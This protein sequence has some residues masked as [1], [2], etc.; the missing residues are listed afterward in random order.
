VT[1]IS[2]SY[3]ARSSLFFIKLL[4]FNQSPSH[5]Y[6]FQTCPLGFQANWNSPRR[7]SFC[8]SVGLKWV[9]VCH[10]SNH[11]TSILSVSCSF[12]LVWKMHPPFFG[13]S[14]ILCCAVL[15]T[16]GC[17]WMICICCHCA[18]ECKWWWVVVSVCPFCWPVC[19]FPFA[20]RYCEYMQYCCQY[21]KEPHVL[22][23]TCCKENTALFFYSILFASCMI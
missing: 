22:F 4:R 14:W 11:I 17:I 2:V 21:N 9:H 3:L 15:E 18:S 1:F 8:H 19:F 10:V 20:S 7:L 5:S 23:S 12:C 6:Q 16:V 13:G